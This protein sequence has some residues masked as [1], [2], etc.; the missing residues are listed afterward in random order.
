MLMKADRQGSGATDKAMGV[1]SAACPVYNLHPRS[2]E[3]G[4]GVE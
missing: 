4:M 1:V 3:R 2:G